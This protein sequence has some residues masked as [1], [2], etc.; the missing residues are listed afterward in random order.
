MN[1]E[2]KE[3][4]TPTLQEFWNHFEGEKTFLQGIK[5]GEFREKLGEK[6]IRLG[7][8]ED[9]KLIG[10]AQC[11][12]I[13][14]RRGTFLHVPH[15]PLVNTTEGYQF[16]LE[17]IKKIGQKEQCDFI[18]IS[19]LL[20]ENNENQN[21][22]IKGKYRNAPLHINP[23]RTWILDLTQDEDEILK[24]MK[25]STR[26][27]V[28]RIEKTGISVKAGNKPTDLDIFWQLHLETV[29]RQG[30]TPFAKKSTETELKIFGDDCQIFSAEIDN[31]FYSSSIILF[32]KK[33]G[34][35]HQGSSIY[36]KAPVAHAT[37]WEAI[38]EAKQ[39]GCTEFNFWGVSP[40]KN[41]KHPWT[42]LSRFKRGF[43]GEEKK[44]VSAQDFPLTNKYWLNYTI[45]R[46]RKW[47]RNY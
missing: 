6:N 37:L 40:S 35:Y 44:F 29:S 32:D 34:Y 33:A 1:F 26:Y 22:F 10:V 19:P 11:Q 38:K 9:K 41:T 4:D 2:L 25:K 43:G 42:G 30:F 5:F 39:R 46:Y 14:A 20:I 17:E 8:F 21:V 18:R 15:G 3:I 45:E 31:K 16:F 47:K 36:S 12:K 24:N 27:E 23:D 13:C 28:R 7:V